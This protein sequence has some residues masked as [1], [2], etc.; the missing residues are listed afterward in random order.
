MI[1]R[2]RMAAKI[3]LTAE[4]RPLAATDL[5]RLREKRHVTPNPQR[6]RESHHMIARLASMGLR[7]KTIAEKVGYSV[8]RVQQLL[9]SPAMVELVANYRAKID[10]EFVENVDEYFTAATTNMLLAERLIA[11]QL[12]DAEASGELP[13]IRTLDAISQGRADRF[14]YGKK[15]QNLNINVDFA[16]QLERAIKRSGK[17]PRTIEASAS[18]LPS[19][20]EPSHPPLASADQPVVAS[21]TKASMLHSPRQSPTPAMP[22]LRRRA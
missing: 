3:P 12:A 16:A 18:A 21:P 6:I 22:R 15:T 20:P 11:D 1:H 10:S 5:E 8:V 7:H 9:D 14:G 17:D 2:G 19:P 13:S 4:P